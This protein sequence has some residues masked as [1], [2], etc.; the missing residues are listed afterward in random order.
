MKLLSII[1][2]TY[3]SENDI[4][5]CLKSIFQYN[6]IGN[7]LEIIIV[8][9]NS[10]NSNILRDNI[11]LLYPDVKFISNNQNSGY[12]QGNNIGIKASTSPY[13]LVMNPD[14]RMTMPIFSIAIE[15]FEK[16]KLD[17]I[18]M[19]QLIKGNKRGNSFF[20]S[21][22]YSPL[23]SIPLTAILNRINLYIPRYMYFSGSC[24]FLRKKFFNKIG[25]FDENIFMYKEE[26]DVHTRTI[27]NNGKIGYI[28]DLKYCHLH[29]DK[30]TNDKLSLKPA[31]LS[32][33]I[34]C[35]LAKKYGNTTKK[36]IIKNMIDECNIMLLREKILKI[37]RNNNPSFE[38]Y[39]KSLKEKLQSIY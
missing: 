38:E 28:K 30:I 25:L 6:D 11:R 23:I 26:L 27:I 9:N 5:D 4:F 22:I 20:W 36:R 16:R 33:E 39:N 37:N 18:G 15:H 10:M 8:D 13:I 2:V 14:V 34:G 1:I 12:G 29:K 7:S 19:K 21:S 24:F 31:L 35:Y 17:I 32:L 3:N